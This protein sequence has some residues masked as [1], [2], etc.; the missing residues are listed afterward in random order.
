MM[1]QTHY[2]TNALRQNDEVMNAL[3]NELNRIFIHKECIKWNRFHT[4]ATST[5]CASIIIIII[6]C[7]FLDNFHLVTIRAIVVILISA[8]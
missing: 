7:D 8:Y 5:H 2:S 6:R 3:N 4:Y 1:L